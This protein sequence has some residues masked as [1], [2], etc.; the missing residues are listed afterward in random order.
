MSK[1]ADAVEL[2][3]LGST[4]QHGLVRIG[5]GMKPVQYG[6]EWELVVRLGTRLRLPQTGD[7][8]E[9]MHR[10]RRNLCENINEYVFGE[11]RTPLLTLRAKLYENGDIENADR[12]SAILDT[13]F[14]S[15]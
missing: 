6:H 15:L 5:G 2:L 4:P 13:M 1:L 8:V 14:R 7:C 9:V 10:A 3:S 12:V 11:F